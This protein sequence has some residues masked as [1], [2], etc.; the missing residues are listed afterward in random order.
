MKINIIGNGSIGSK[1]MS[2]STLLDNHILVDV[3]NGVTKHLKCLG[4]DVLAI[5]TILL[6]HFHGDH[7]F[8]IPFFLL[9]KFFY[10]DTRKLTIVGPRGMAEKIEQ[11][12]ELGFPNTWNQL[13]ECYEIQFIEYNED[14]TIQLENMQI[15]AKEV[16]HADLKPAYGYIVE[17]GREKDWIFWRFLLL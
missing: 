10:Q 1:Y 6:T 3:P 16:Q 2:A 4:Y 9:N 11:L 13:M 8:D 5:D 12:V 15:Q 14:T 7:F 17:I